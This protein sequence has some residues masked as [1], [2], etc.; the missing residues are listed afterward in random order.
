VILSRRLVYWYNEETKTPTSIVDW[1][2][3]CD[4]SK[5]ILHITVY[6]TEQQ[7]FKEIVGFGIRD[8]EALSNVQYLPNDGVRTNK[9]TGFS[10]FRGLYP[11]ACVLVL[12][13]VIF[14][15]SKNTWAVSR[16]SC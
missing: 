10:S 15:G 7:D 3:L 11:F 9:K 12:P 4:E 5:D 2:G 13:C 1:I 8:G 14:V 16:V 6:S